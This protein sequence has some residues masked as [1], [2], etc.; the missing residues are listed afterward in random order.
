MRVIRKKYEEAK[1]YIDLINKTNIK[2]IDWS[3]FYEF[4]SPELIEDFE[5]SGLNNTDFIESSYSNNLKKVED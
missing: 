2:E 1:S 3:E 5:M 4:V